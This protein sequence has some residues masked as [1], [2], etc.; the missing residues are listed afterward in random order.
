LLLAIFVLAL[1]WS[2]GY[3]EIKYVETFIENQDVKMKNSVIHYSK[4]NTPLGVH[5][6]IAQSSRGVCRIELARTESEFLEDLSRRW[7]DMELIRNSAALRKPLA[8]LAEYFAG[9]RKKFTLPLSLEGTAFQKKVWRA[10]SK[11]RYGQV[12]SYK[13]IAGKLRMPQAVRAVGHA[14][15]QNPLP[16]VVPCHRVIGSD[17]DLC[18]YGGGIELKKK[19][20]ELEGHLFR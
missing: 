5:L 10:V 16:I 8:E 6:W 7:P 19:L 3:I 20:L 15:G 18:G 9:R 13:Q 1:D 17:G 14:N 4:F 12:A 11:I 2:D